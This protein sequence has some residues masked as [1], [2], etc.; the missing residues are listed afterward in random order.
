MAEHISF[1]VNGTPR[2]LDVEPR[3]LLVQAIREDLDLTG[4]EVSETAIQQLQT[5]LPGLT[6][7]DPNW[8][9]RPSA[10]ESQVPSMAAS[11]DGG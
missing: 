1:V 6:V 2:E 7:I 9:E 5:K 4:T 10:R 3:R 11:S 8:R